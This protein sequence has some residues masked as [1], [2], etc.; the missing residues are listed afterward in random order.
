MTEDANLSYVEGLSNSL[1]RLV[2]EERMQ[3]KTKKS[4]VRLIED[5]EKSSSQ[6]G[7]CSFFIR[8]SLDLSCLMNSGLLCEKKESSTWCNVNPNH[9]PFILDTIDDST[10]RIYSRRN[11]V[12]EVE[13]ARKISKLSKVEKN[14]SEESKLVVSSFMD[15]NLPNHL[16]LSD[17]QFDAIQTSLKYGFSIISGGPGT[18]K[19]TT[20][21]KYLEA[22]LKENPA[23]IIS[24]VA[25]TG[26]AQSR[27]L[28]SV[29]KQAGASRDLFPMVNQALRN[30]RLTASTIHKLLLTP[31]LSGKMPSKK[32]PLNCDFLV[33]DES[34]MIDTFLALQL[35]QAIDPQKTTSL[36]LGDMHQLAAVGPGSMF[37]DISEP[38]GPLASQ[39]S[40]L[41]KSF[42]FNAENGI[43]ILSRAI[44]AQEDF[45]NL[46]NK[47][48]ETRIF[49]TL[50]EL[51][52][53]NEQISWNSS[54]TPKGEKLTSAAQQW[55]KHHILAYKSVVH[56]EL[57]KEAP[58]EK[59]LQKVWQALNQFK[60]LAALR[61]G[62]MGINA[63]N[64]FSELIMT[65]RALNTEAPSLYE[66]KPII[67]RENQNLFSISNGDVAFLYRKNGKWFAY[68]GDLQRSVDFYLLPSFDTA[69]AMTIHQSQGSGFPEVGIFLPDQL[70]LESNSANI[71]TRELLYTA[72]TRAE[73]K[74]CIFATQEILSKSILTKTERNGGLKD[75]IKEA[76]SD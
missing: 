69:F 1:L 15:P 60:A 59:S 11:F 43:G 23:A 27:L 64:E 24:L 25:P 52:S 17:E 51:S 20:V 32:N 26:K 22:V 67:I 75:R 34:S 63:L 53:L 45:S 46:P 2:P 72:I 47:K 61:K 56:Q 70:D 16:R 10:Y 44:N 55:L 62:P 48:F 57:H 66:G 58:S 7:L 42:R 41:E 74:C 3:P 39:V 21:V 29:K 65:E 18:G 28:E 6:G 38:S 50:R 9:A 37:A 12:A 73:E 68:I 5:L 40:V 8:D 13:L 36:F 19:T 33:V 54:N 71:C 4:L 76:L 35:F 14:I 31:T 49:Q 30:S